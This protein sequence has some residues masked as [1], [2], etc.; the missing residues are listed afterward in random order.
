M[1]PLDFRQAFRTLSIRALLVVTEE[2]VG[3][4][5]IGRLRKKGGTLGLTVDTFKRT[6]GVGRGDEKPDV[7]PEYI[8]FKVIYRWCK[9]D[10][11][12]IVKIRCINCDIMRYECRLPF[13]QVMGRRETG[14][15]E[16]TIQCFLVSKSFCKRPCPLK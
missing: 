4:R 11:G 2:G 8:S 1:N 6:C 14:R 10:P 5:R 7:F 16:K 12:D 13:G 3:E 15:Y 9:V